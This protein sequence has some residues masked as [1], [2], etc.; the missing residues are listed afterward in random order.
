[1]TDKSGHCQMDEQKLLGF[2]GDYAKLSMR[3][4]YRWKLKCTCIPHHTRSFIAAKVRTEWRSVKE[5][6]TSREWPKAARLSM[7]CVL[8]IH[9]FANGIKSTA[10][11]QQTNEKKLLRNIV[12]MPNSYINGESNWKWRNISQH[13]IHAPSLCNNNWNPK[14]KLYE[15]ELF[16][17]DSIE[18]GWCCEGAGAR[19]VWRLGECWFDR[20]FSALIETIAINVCMLCLQF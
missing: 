14:R 4:T 15:N 5:K 19:M 20:A 7:C 3:D 17:V 8:P 13:R 1:M 12:A 18:S 2:N 10:R 16:V 9:R 11:V 6:K